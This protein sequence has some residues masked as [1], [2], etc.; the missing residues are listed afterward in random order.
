MRKH[1]IHVRLFLN[2]KYVLRSDVKVS[3]MLN[4]CS[5]EENHKCKRL[6]EVDLERYHVI[7]WLY[8]I[9]KQNGRRY[10][11][12]Q[13]DF[14]YVIFG[15]L[16][17]KSKVRDDSDIRK[18]VR[19]WCKNPTAAEAKY[20]HISTWNTF[21]VTNMSGLFRSQKFNDDISGWD[22]SGCTNMIYMFNASSFDGDISK[23]KVNKVTN[24]REMFS[25]TDYKGVLSQWSW[26]MHND[27]IID[28][29]FKFCSIGEEYKCKRLPT[30]LIERSGI[31]MWLYHIKIQNGNNYDFLRPD[32]VSK[33]FG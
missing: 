31:V 26:R 4:N 7:L 17:S 1:L 10:G 19:A 32:F 3:G 30:F 20:G 8:H 18:A 11:L 9:R 28:G 13:P 14:M 5:T 16:L 24:M 2:G 23:W 33:V 27:V 25:S 6:R 29:M 22:V 21:R 12:L 15:R